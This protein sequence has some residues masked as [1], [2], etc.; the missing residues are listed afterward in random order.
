[1]PFDSD[2]LSLRGSYSYSDGFFQRTVHYEADEGGYRVTKY[3]HLLDRPLRRLLP[4]IPLSFIHPP[5]ACREE[6]TPIGDGPRYNPLGTAD[7]SSSLT[8][9]Y[10]ITAD[11]FKTSSTT[12]RSDRK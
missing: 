12:E 3:A 7:V 2:G 1:M 6:I 5:L 9:S 10:S 4:F 11:D 8:G